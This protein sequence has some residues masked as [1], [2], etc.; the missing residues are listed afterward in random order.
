MA[1]QCL[2]ISGR[3]GRLSVLDEL[4]QR[5]KRR[6]IVYKCKCDCGNFTNVAGI[7]LNSGKTQSCGCLQKEAVGSINKTHGMCA[8]PLYTTWMGMRSRCNNLKHHKYPLY[9]GRGIKIC[10]RWDCFTLFVEDV[11][12]RPENCS[13][14]RINNDGDY[15][16]SNV[17]WSTPLEQASNRRPRTDEQLRNEDGTFMRKQGRPPSLQ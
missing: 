2:K 8:H 4:K 1:G 16:P 5:N 15:K 6:Q 14:D 9:G 3:Y 10:S 12:K 13:L 17:K 11:G 7:M